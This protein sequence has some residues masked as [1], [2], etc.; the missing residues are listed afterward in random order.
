HEVGLSSSFESLGVRAG[1]GK[2][3]GSLVGG[4]AHSQPVLRSLSAFVAI[5]SVVALADRYWL[6]ARGYLRAGLPFKE[7][8]EAEGAENGRAVR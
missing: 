8:G 2:A 4:L 5:A 1:G 6:R 7:D 3:W